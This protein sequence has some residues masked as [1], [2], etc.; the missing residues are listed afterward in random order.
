MMFVLGACWA[1]DSPRQVFGL[2]AYVFTKFD[3]KTPQ[4]VGAKCEDCK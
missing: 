2:K 4:F 3:V 1:Q